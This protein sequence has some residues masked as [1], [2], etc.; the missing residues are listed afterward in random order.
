MQYWR[1]LEQ[2]A[3]GPEMRELIDKEFPGYDPENIQ[4]SSRRSFLKIMSAS[5]ALAGVTLTGCRRWPK[6]RL[7]PLVSEKNLLLAQD[8]KNKYEGLNDKLAQSKTVL[9]LLDP[10]FLRSKVCQA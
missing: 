8:L 4:T 3:D 6:E 5:L 7:A 9:T 1:S 2:L 10:C